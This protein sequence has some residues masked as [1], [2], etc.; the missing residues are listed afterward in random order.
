MTESAEAG[1][2][3][4]GP[5]TRPGPKVPERFCPDPVELPE[6]GPGVEAQSGVFESIP[7]G[8]AS[9]VSP[10]RRFGPAGY[11]DAHW[12]GPFKFG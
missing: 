8:P 11:I 9:P 12:S 10:A 5:W 1:R 4:N 3:W 7:P 6:F 2:F